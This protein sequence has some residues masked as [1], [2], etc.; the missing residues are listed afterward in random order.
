MYVFTSCYK[1]FF[2]M[3]LW[4]LNY[5]SNSENVYTGWIGMIRNDSTKLGSISGRK[6]AICEY[7]KCM[8]WMSHAID[9]LV[10]IWSYIRWLNVNMQLSSNCHIFLCIFFPFYSSFKITT[11][12]LKTNNYSYSMAIS[13]HT[14][15]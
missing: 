4:K 12:F 6:Q 8:H 13:I 14:S 2:E 9:I 10:Y 7:V 11:Q 5:S 3:K 1:C 15:N